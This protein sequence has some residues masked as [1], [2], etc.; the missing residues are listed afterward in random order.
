M[1]RM[2]VEAELWTEL[3]KEASYQD[4][5]IR[6]KAAAFVESGRT[7]EVSGKIDVPLL[8]SSGKPVQSSPDAGTQVPSMVVAEV[9]VSEKVESDEIPDEI[10]AEL[11][12]ALAADWTAAIK[13]GQAKMFEFLMNDDEGLWAEVRQDIFEELKEKEQELLGADKA[14][15]SE[16]LQDSARQA[17][18]DAFDG[19]WEALAQDGGYEWLLTREEA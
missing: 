7:Q 3:L 2:A 19:L 1:I 9:G 12:A 10:Y 17:L 14:E 8:D 11:G 18:A 5:L 15:I 13:A 4:P 16:A 6:E